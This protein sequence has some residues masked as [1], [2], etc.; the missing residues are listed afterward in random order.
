[1][2]AWF[3]WRIRCES[4]GKI[5]FIRI[6]H[7]CRRMGM[8]GDG[9][10]SK[11]TRPDPYIKRFNPSRPRKCAIKLSSLSLMLRQI[12]KGSLKCKHQA[13]TLSVIRKYR[14]LK[15]H[16]LHRWS[17]EPTRLIEIEQYCD[18]THGWTRYMS[19]LWLRFQQSPFP[20]LPLA[21]LVTLRM[22][23]SQN[24]DCTF[25]KSRLERLSMWW[26]GEI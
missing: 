6:V 7:R 12:T 21:R 5:F 15:L 22:T 20:V 2:R 4:A 8:L 19:N 11:M 9:L 26:R 13:T 16:F 24:S 18:T 14:Y 17:V 3:S 23:A 10:A 25:L 1:M